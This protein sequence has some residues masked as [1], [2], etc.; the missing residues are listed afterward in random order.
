MASIGEYY[1]VTLLGG[2][3]G[4][5]RQTCECFVVSLAEEFAVIAVAEGF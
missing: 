2:A 4:G 5:Q 3:A 1:Y